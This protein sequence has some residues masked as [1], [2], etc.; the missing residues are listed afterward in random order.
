MDVCARCAC[1]CICFCYSFVF[2]WL[3]S[4]RFL[5]ADLHIQW[6]MIMP[7]AYFRIIYLLAAIQFYFKTIISAHCVELLRCGRFCLCVHL[8]PLPP[9]SVHY[10][11]ARARSRKFVTFFHSASLFISNSLVL[12][13]IVFICSRWCCPSYFVIPSTARTNYTWHVANV[14]H[15]FSTANDSRTDAR[16]FV[17]ACV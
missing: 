15:I 17:C 4:N 7:V 16:M 2:A 10:V 5:F 11:R 1:V 3:N 13:I 8:S 12:H 14:T 6:P 9:F